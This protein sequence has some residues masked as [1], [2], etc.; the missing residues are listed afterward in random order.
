MEP[1]IGWVGFCQSERAGSQT[2]GTHEQK[3]CRCECVWPDGRMDQLCLGA[4][5]CCVQWDVMGLEAGK[6]GKGQVGLSLDFY[7]GD[8]RVGI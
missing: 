6:V 3:T 2:E 5:T 4:E 8:F 1:N 7:F